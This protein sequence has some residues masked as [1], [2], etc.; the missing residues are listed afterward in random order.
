MVKAGIWGVG[1]G[2]PERV[3]TNKELEQMVDT[4]DEWI[5]S[6]TGIRER[7]IAD[8][9]QA[10][11]DLAVMAGRKALA[12]AHVSV[13]EIDL[14]IV[15]TVTP[16]T[17]FP[18]TAC[19]VQASIGAKQAAA[20]DLSAGCSG[21]IYAL[22]MATRCVEAGAYHRVLVIGADTLSRITDW[23]DRST[24][25]L[26]GDGAGACIVGPVK[27]GGILATYLGAD[28][29]GGDKLC[30]PAGGSRLPLTA[31]IMQEGRQFIQMAGNEVFKFAVR[32]MGDAAVEVIQRAGLTAEDIGLFVPHQANIR[33]IDAAAKRLGLPTEKVF[34][35]VHR[36]GNTSAASIPIALGEAIEQKSVKPGDNMVLVGF[37]AGLTWGA[38]ALQ[39]VAEE[40]QL[41]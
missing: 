37:G 36:Y 11:S 33:I 14:I 35:N 28:G 41:R 4:N 38:A 39:W 16:D 26:F 12:D 31:E 34:I 20:F 22:D 2:L 29:T 32:I 1:I 27:Q 3:L 9:T 15:A 30:I 8:P 24:C 23:T 13:E 17:M 6:R 19:L 40:D 10:T 18:A 5:T 21:F 25:V 7:R